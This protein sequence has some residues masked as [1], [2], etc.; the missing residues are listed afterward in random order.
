M[1]IKFSPHPACNLILFQDSI[2]FLDYKGNKKCLDNGQPDC[3]KVEILCFF[4]EIFLQNNAK[5]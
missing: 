2:L 5:H 1:K 3:L 4:V